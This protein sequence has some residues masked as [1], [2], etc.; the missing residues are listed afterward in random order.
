MVQL[1]PEATFDQVIDER[2]TP[3]GLL[4]SRMFNVKRAIFVPPTNVPAVTERFWQD[5]NGPTG[6]PSA[7]GGANYASSCSFL[8]NVFLLWK[9][10]S[11]PQ[12]FPSTFFNFF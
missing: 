11:V 1:C 6:P 3:N 10:P 7:V 9:T 2:L 8:F 12:A 5:L 4:V